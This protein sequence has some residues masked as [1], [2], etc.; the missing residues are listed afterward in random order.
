MGSTNSTAPVE[1]DLLA[2]SERNQAALADALDEARRIADT[3]GSALNAM[4]IAAAKDITPSEEAV[5]HGHGVLRAWQQA[6]SQLAEISRTVRKGA[7][8]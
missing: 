6:D 7:A 4:L 5:E 8:R 2:I 1:R 3:L